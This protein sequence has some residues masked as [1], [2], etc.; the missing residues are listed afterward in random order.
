MSAT[1]HPRG[2][3]DAPHD[4]IGLWERE[5]LFLANG[6]T[7]GSTRVF[8]GQTRK[9]YIDIRVPAG[10]PRVAA[11]EVATLPDDALRALA[12][13]KGFAG[14]ILLRDQCC[15]WFRCIDFQ[16]DTGRPDQAIVRLQG[17]VLYEEGSPASV[18]GASYQ[19]VYR[20]TSRGS[21]RCVALSL[22]GCEDHA[23]GGRFAGKALLIVLDDRFLFARARPTALPR[24]GSLEELLFD[25]SVVP[26]ERMRY[27][28][29]EI[30]IGSL[31]MDGAGFVVELSTHPWREGSPLLHLG[32]ASI[33]SEGLECFTA[34]TRTRW[35][36]LESN[37]PDEQLA[38]MFRRKSR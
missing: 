19:E 33:G 26:I 4:L 34:G 15:T 22:A 27:L 29:C 28:D 36:V 8:W 17:D 10:R 6:T 25:T 5:C 24:A 9:R 11:E 31:A 21:R 13:Q 30:S 2:V 38:A 12:R 1:K 16:P 35:H 37:L 18:V 7:D 14:H 20:R 3:P 23:F 32:E